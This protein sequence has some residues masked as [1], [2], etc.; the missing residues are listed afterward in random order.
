M[1]NIVSKNVK[2][3]KNLKLLEGFT[4]LDTIFNF[5]TYNKKHIKCYY[6]FVLKNE[7]LFWWI[8]PISFYFY[9]LFTPLS[10]IG[11]FNQNFFIKS[12]FEK[13]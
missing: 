4:F 5:V 8:L 12:N 3:S 11:S 9:P 2:P 13:A 1:D 7:S 6:F 10:K